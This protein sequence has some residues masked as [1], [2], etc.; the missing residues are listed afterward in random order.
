MKC[1]YDSGE[2]RDDGKCRV[3]TLYNQPSHAPEKAIEVGT[4][5]DRKEG[6]KR[7]LW[8]DPKTGE[9]EAEYVEVGD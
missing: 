1:I 3:V 7:V 8:V 6:Y 2:S 5:P 4:V 9:M